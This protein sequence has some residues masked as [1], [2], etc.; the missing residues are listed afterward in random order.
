ML[1]DLGNMG[2]RRWLSGS[3][4]DE[5]LLNQWP[6]VCTGETQMAPLSP[7]EADMCKGHRGVL[8]DR[9]GDLGEHS[10]PL[11]KD[12]ANCKPSEWQISRAQ[13]RR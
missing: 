13:G 6:P 4:S 3:E 7:C 9:G 5:R 8:R 10:L 2:N 11:R 12:T 1:C